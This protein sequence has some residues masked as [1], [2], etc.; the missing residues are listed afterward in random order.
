MQNLFYVTSQAPNSISPNEDFFANNG[1]SVGT[2]KH[3]SNLAIIQI[4]KKKDDR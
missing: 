3:N 4:N 2:G 1:Q